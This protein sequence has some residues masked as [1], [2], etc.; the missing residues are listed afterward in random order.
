MNTNEMRIKGSVGSRMAIKLAKL[1]KLHL[2]S[3]AK[4]VIIHL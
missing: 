1:A 4:W 2:N 3:S